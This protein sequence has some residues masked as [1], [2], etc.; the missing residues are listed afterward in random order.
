MDE[1]VFSEKA[2]FEM[3]LIALYNLGNLQQGLKLHHDADP[4]LI[5]A[6]Q[7]LFEKDLIT[8]VDG[9]YL[10]SSGQV[11]AEHLQALKTALS[12]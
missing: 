4:K 5:E 7:R 11:L 8:Q 12:A 9:G 2:Q 10:T 3:E 6:A 1:K